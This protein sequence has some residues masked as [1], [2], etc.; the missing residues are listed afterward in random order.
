MFLES[1]AITGIKAI[2]PTTMV[3]NETG[4]LVCKK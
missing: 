4:K 3:M 2:K 1:R